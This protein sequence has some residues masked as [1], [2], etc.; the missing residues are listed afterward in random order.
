MQQAAMDYRQYHNLESYLFE[1]V[2]CRFQ[3]HGYL[4]VE[5]FFCIVIWKAN[6]AKSKIAAKLLQRGDVGLEAAVR[7]LTTG[8][9]S[10]T[11]P[12]DRLHYLLKVWKFRLAM[13]SAI[14]S[15]LYPDEFTVYDMRVCDALGRFHRLQNLVSFASIWDG[16]VRFKRAVETAAPQGLSLRDKDR[17]LWGRSFY[18]QLTKDIERE[19]RAQGQERD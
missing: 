19:F 3:E 9:D 8:V 5:D 2:H 1:V 4:S 14:L 15:V 18:E 13:A 6:R 10:M 17:Y 12:K 7:R 11:T 16:Y